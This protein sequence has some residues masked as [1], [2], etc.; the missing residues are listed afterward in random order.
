MTALHAIQFV[1]CMSLVVFILLLISIHA[2]TDGGMIAKM[3]SASIPLFGFCNFKIFS[4]VNMLLR[5]LS[6]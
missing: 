5:Q 6:S 3:Y 2:A 1:H 4:H